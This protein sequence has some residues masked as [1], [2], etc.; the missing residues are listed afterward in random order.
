MNQKL[1][2]DSFWDDLAR[3]RAALPSTQDVSGVGGLTIHAH[4]GPGDGGPLVVGTTDTGA[5]QGSILFAGV[6]G[7]QQQDNSNLF[8]DDTNNYLGIG[9]AGS[10]QKQLHI[11]NAGAPPTLRFERS[12]PVAVFDWDINASGQLR[13]LDGASEILRVDATDARWFGSKHIMKNDTTNVLGLNTLLPSAVLHAVGVFASNQ[14][15]IIQGAAGQSG[16]L[17]EWQNSAGTAL[18][19]VDEDGYIGAGISSPASPL[20]V[21]QSGAAA[22]IPAVLIDQGDLDQPVIQVRGDGTDQDM[23]ILRVEMTGTPQVNWTEASDAFDTSHALGIRAALANAEGLY[24][25]WVSGD[26]D[27]TAYFGSTN[28][29][30][31]QNAVEGYSYSAIGVQGTTTSSV[32]VYGVATSGTGGLFTSSTGIPLSANLTG[33]GTYIAAF[34]DNGVNILTIND[35][36]NILLGPSATLDLNGIADVLILDTD[37][38]TTIS[39]PTDDQIDFEV[40]GSDVVVMDA[41]GLGINIAPAQTLHVYESAANSVVRIESDAINSRAGINFLNDAR[42]WQIGVNTSDDYQIRDNTG[43]ANVLVLT[44]GSLTNSIYTDSTGVGIRT[45]SPAAQLHVD[46]LSTTAAIPVLTLDQADID[47]VLMKI[48][49]TAA[50]A[51]VDRTLVADS[52]FGTPGALVGWYQVEI[53]DDGARIANGDYYVPIYAAPS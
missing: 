31:N 21:D 42:E 29:S 25:P 2:L 27:A 41:T 52:D 47:V 34:R 32:G 37:A 50:A 46:Q 8:W 18:S 44:D 36:G 5:T 24:V 17:T 26:A 1:G 6:G 48:I 13:W 10:P 30:N 12:G 14:V 45:A 49:G 38:D 28:A 53:Q 35:G 4:S 16:N 11:K 33:V 23:A 20:H 3:I 15:E 51:S 19:V 40:G 7:V 43:G 39:A 22:A 9:T